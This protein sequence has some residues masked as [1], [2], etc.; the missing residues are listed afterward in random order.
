[1]TNLE[2]VLKIISTHPDAPC[3]FLEVE[4]L[5]DDAEVFD[6]ASDWYEA[7]KTEGQ[8]GRMVLSMD[9]PSTRMLGFSTYD[10]ANEEDTARY[11]VVA[12]FRFKEEAPDSIREYFKTP[13]KRHGLAEMLAKGIAPDWNA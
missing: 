10:P 3:Y 7:V 5:P 6:T 12:L 8:K 1:M 11:L 2:E 4:P 13:Q 9:H